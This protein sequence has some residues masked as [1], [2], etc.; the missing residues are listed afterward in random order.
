MNLLFSES[1]DSKQFYIDDYLITIDTWQNRLFKYKYNM[2]YICPRGSYIGNDDWL[3]YR[4]KLSE[5]DDDSK[6]GYNALNRYLKNLRKINSN[7][8]LTAKELIKRN[9]SKDFAGKTFETQYK[10][11]K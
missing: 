4:Y 1:L 2:V 7:M 10:E 3:G 8:R 11:G 5:N 6:L 9:A